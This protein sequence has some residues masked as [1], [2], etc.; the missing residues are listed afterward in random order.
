MWGL[1]TIKKFLNT[2]SSTMR[3]GQLF[4]APYL[5]P[6]SELISVTMIRGNIISSVFLIGMY[7]NLN[8]TLEKVDIT[9]RVKYFKS[10]R[11][12]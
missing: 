10:S 5:I 1:Y 6:N 9:H 8:Q 4:L 11:A 7:I 12:N 3:Y 2:I